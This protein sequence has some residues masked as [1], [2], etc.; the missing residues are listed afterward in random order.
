VNKRR[1]LFLYVAAAALA[2]SAVLAQPKQAP[3]LIGWLSWSRRND[4][5]RNSF[6]EGMAALGWREG[7]GYALEGRWAEGQVDRLPGLARELAEKKPALIVATPTPSARAAA[8][9]APGTPIVV[10]GGDPVPAG[11]VKSYAR[12]GGMITGLSSVFTE[13]SEKFLE[14]LLAAAPGSRRV[15][16]L[17]DLNASNVGLLKEN[18]RRSVGQLSVEARIA[19]V[20]R[21]EDI[22]P[23]LARFAKDGIDALIALY[24]AA[25]GE[26]LRVAKFALARGWPV[27]GG[28]AWSRAFSHPLPNDRAMS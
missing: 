25:A 5:F 21:P 18:A 6:Y 3:V 13:I 4:T 20:A 27:I 2:P 17:F 7:S 1:H 28:A 16:F 12:P 11:L 24:G 9:A 19:D 14:L 23:A 22:E 8:M 15:G 10:V 26:R